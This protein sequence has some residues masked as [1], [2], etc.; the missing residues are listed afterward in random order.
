[1][2]QVHRAGERVFIDYSGDTVAVRPEERRDPH[3]RDLRGDAGRVEV[4]VRRGDVDANSAGLDRFE[5]PDAG[6]LRVGPESVD[7]RFCSRKHNRAPRR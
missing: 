4:R 5:Y 2:R 7:P 1:M 6:V 3:R